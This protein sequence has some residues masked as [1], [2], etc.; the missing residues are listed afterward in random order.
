VPE[1]TFHEIYDILNDDTDFQEEYIA[2]LRETMVNTFNVYKKVN[3]GRGDP[4][5]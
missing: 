4:D 2:K 5:V 3:E 1:L